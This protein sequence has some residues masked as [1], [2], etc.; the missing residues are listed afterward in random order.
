MIFHGDSRRWVG[1][2]PEMVPG[3]NPA[4]YTYLSLREPRDG[5]CGYSWASCLWLVLGHRVPWHRMNYGLSLILASNLRAHGL[6]LTHRSWVKNNFGWVWMALR[7]EENKRVCMWKVME[8]GRQGAE[9]CGVLVGNTGRKRE[10]YE[11][12]VVP[13]GRD[14]RVGPVESGSRWPLLTS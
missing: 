4:G 1:A 13:P 8:G 2:P 7:D 11:A 5:L 14:L 10:V 3:L 6:G 9:G 12:S